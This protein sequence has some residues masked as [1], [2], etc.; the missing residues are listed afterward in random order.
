MKVA[1]LTF[2]N[3]TNYGAALQCYAL[4]RSLQLLGAEAAVIQYNG[5]YLNKPY[6]IAALKEKG[7][8]RYILGNVWTLLRKPR[9]K[10]FRKFQSNIQFTRCVNEK[11][12]HELEAEY[13]L[14]IT[15][16]DQV[17]NGSLTAYDTNYFLSF[18]KNISKKASYAAS[19]G[20]LKVPEEKKSWY[21]E[22]LTGFK[23][24]NVRETSGQDIVKEVTGSEAK[25]TIDPTLLLTSDEWEKVMAPHELN[26]P[27]ILT[28]QISPCRKMTEVI[29]K[30]KEETGYKV[31]AIPFV[32]DFYFNYQS[33]INIGPAEFISLI[34]NA[35][36]I[37][38]DSFHGT[39]FSL[40]FNKNFW[41]LSSRKESRITSILKILGLD[42]RIIYFDDEL[43]QNLLESVAY[44]E[45][46]ARLEEYRQNALSL[47]KDMID[48]K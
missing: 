39:A 3:T 24:Y 16:S 37:V 43:H 21:N 15:G 23:Y 22:N 18:V 13:D 7:V 41:S 31:I 25:L 32:M 4:Y 45:A 36:Y 12:I 46:G 38:T 9:S 17:W 30:I 5:P 6:K 27:Y 1:T 2:Q 34:K 28:Y 26:E 10:Q 20:F 8:V 44:N 14:F 40:I 48:G 11:T 42:Q 29:K 35:S 47:L 19:F 33:R